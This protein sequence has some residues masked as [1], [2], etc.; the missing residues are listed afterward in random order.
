MTE[1]NPDAYGNSDN[2][3]G[4]RINCIRCVYYEVTWEPDRP[5]GCTMFGFKGPRMPCVTVLETTGK[6]CPAFTLK[7]RK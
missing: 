2:T 5:H 3:T 4:S 6:P 1:F 7:I